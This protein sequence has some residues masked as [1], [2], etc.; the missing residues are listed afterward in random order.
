MNEVI[1]PQA[2]FVPKFSAENRI[3]TQASEI[4]NLHVAS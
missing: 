1:S 3:Q 4:K 2:C